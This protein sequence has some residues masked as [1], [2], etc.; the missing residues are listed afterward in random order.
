MGLPAA[1]AI[2]FACYALGCVVP[3]Y[4]AVKWK[5]GR[6]LRRSGSGTTG[7][8]NAGRLLGKKAYVLL[9][10]L[11]MGKGALAMALAAWSGLSGWWLAGAGLAV[12][13][14]HLWP[15]QLKFHGGKGVAVSYGVILFVSPVVAALMWAVFG[16]GRLAMRSTTLG[17]VQAFMGAPL[18][19][20][21]LGAGEV[22]TL[23]F[24]ILGVTVTLT[25]RQN[26]R[27][28]LQRRRGNLPASPSETSPA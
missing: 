1:V 13:A 6:D 26:V 18:L 3:S 10:L 7:A 2:L 4:Y 27:D 5:T 19:A 23:L 22:V 21:A 8:T 9:A 11:D 20:L 28:A 16:C 14:G 25:H 15:A 17:M 24:I 12:T